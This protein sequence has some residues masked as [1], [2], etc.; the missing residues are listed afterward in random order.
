M[1]DFVS[2]PGLNDEMDRV[3]AARRCTGALLITGGKVEGADE[4]SVEPKAAVCCIRE[5][6]GRRTS[7]DTVLDPANSFTIGLASGTSLVDAGA[8]DG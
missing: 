4:S 2:G 3:A 5:L 8:V 1:V 6:D 7:A